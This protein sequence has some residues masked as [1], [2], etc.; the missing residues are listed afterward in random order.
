MYHNGNYR[1]C[2]SERE[3]ERER[4]RIYWN[5]IID[6]IN[7]EERGMTTLASPMPEEASVM[8][9]TSWVMSSAKGEERKD[10]KSLK[11]Y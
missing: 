11:K 5:Y 10:D 3:R 7:W 8:T 2:L 4:E 9:T 6:K 1:I